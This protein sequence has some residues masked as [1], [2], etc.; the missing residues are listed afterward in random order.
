VAQGTNDSLIAEGWIQGK[1]CLLTIDTGA[2]VTIVQPDIAAGQPANSEGGVGR[3]LERRP[4]T[5]WVVVAEI[6]DDFILRLDVLRAYDASVDLGRHLLRLE[7]EEVT[8]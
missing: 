5:F 4:L 2:S 7:Q 1:L 3:A 8:L 6:T